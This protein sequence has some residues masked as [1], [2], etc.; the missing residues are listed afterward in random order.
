M[1]SSAGRP[2]AL[3]AAISALEADGELMADVEVCVNNLARVRDGR[4]YVPSEGAAEFSLALTP[5]VALVLE[6]ARSPIQ[7]ADLVGKLA[8][9]FPDVDKHRRAALVTELLRTRLLR[10]ALRAAATIVDPATVCPP[11]LPAPAKPQ[12]AAVDVRLDADVRLPETVAVEMETAATVL[13][14]LATVPGRNPAWRRYA[15]RFADRWG[16]G[17]EVGLEQLTDP[18]HGLGFPEGFG[19]VS[20]PPRPMTRRDRLL[21][22]LA[23]AAALEGRR[24]VTLSEPMIE[25]LEAAAGGPPTVLAPHLE[26]SAQV[27]ARSIPALD[28]GDF[29]VRVHTVSRAAGSMTGRFWHLFPEL[30]AEHAALPTVDPEAELAQLSFHPARIQADLLTRAPQVLPRLVSVGEFRGN[31]EEVLRARRSGRWPSR[32]PPLPCGGRHRGARGVAGPHR[33][34]LR[35][36]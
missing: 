18:D 24:T 12:A 7:H 32:R 33:D 19:V 6:A 22:Q 14:R 35:V 21:L 25:E 20:E 16:E 10:S 30:N 34:Q 17:T 8:A 23:G 26:L 29:R 11:A 28:K 27:Q 9:E 15:E 31:T 5:A 36:E 3:E 4:V 2:V 1:R 13:A